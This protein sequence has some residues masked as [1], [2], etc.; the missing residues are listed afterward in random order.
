MKHR[1]NIL[2]Y[3]LHDFLHFVVLDSVVFH[4]LVELYF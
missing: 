2:V 1:Q 3:M 4:D